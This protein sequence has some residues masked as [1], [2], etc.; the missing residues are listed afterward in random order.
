MKCYNQEVLYIAFLF[1]VLGG[2][3]VY[4]YISNTNNRPPGP[5]NMAPG[6]PPLTTS[7]KI[8]LWGGFGLLIFSALLVFIAAV[9]SGGSG[10]AGTTLG[11]SPLGL[12]GGGG[13]NNGGSGGP[14]ALSGSSPAILI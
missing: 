8:Q 1:M 10:T 5:G 11:W 12:F 4:W 7:Q 9:R 14:T 2:I 6:N 13:G 3:L